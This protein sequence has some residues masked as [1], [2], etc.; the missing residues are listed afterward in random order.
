MLIF[1]YTFSI[2][3]EQLNS[4]LSI[5]CFIFLPRKVD[6]KEKNIIILILL[7][8]LTS[9]TDMKIN[10]NAITIFQHY[11]PIWQLHFVCYAISIDFF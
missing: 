9:F 7:E 4:M 10:W 11:D 8:N 6:T 5:L 2:V 1:F 3:K